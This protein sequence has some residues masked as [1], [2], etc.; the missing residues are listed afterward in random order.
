[1]GKC[2]ENGYFYQ[3]WLSNSYPYVISS[4]KSR[5][6]RWS[7]KSRSSILASLSILSS[8][9]LLALEANYQ[10]LCW[11]EKTVQPEDPPAHEDLFPPASLPPPSIPLLLAL[12]RVHVVPGAQDEEKEL[13]AF[14]IQS[15]PEVRLSPACLAVPLPHGPPSAALSPG[16][17]L[18]V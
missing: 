7:W 10:R 8:F 13:D 16:P 14:S 9:S 2:K 6:P 12:L 17:S 11:C 18:S 3:M 5:W 4:C 15:L 1:M